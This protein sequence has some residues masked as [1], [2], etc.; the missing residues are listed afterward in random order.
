MVN[1]LIKRK[2]KVYGENGNCSVYA[3]EAAV[4]WI[5]DIFTDGGA[6]I[7]TQKIRGG[8][9]TFEAVP[10]ASITQWETADSVY[11]VSN[12]PGL[13]ITTARVKGDSI[14]APPLD[15]GGARGMKPSGM[16]STNTYQAYSDS[17][18]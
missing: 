4:N 14:L 8:R 13:R 18:L 17:L 11:V 6:D 1:Q 2:P 5:K 12:S 7:G 15:S 3:Y 9:M 16:N 10:S